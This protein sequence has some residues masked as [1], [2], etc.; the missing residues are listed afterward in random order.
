MLKYLEIDSTY[1]NRN[2][3][4]NQTQF[5]I[6]NSQNGSNFTLTTS[7]DPISIA[8][9]IV[10]YIPDDISLLNTTSFINN[11]AQ[12]PDSKI[13]SFPIS[14]KANKTS[15][16]YRGLSLNVIVN[17]GFDTNLGPVIVD[18]WD[19]LNTVDGNDCFRILFESSLANSTNSILII[20]FTISTNFDQGYVFIPNGTLASQTYKDFYIYNETQ[21]ESAIILS[22]DGDFAL[23]SIDPKP[24]WLTSDT[25]SLRK[26][27][28][29]TYG[30]FQSGSTTSS[31]VLSAS[32]DPA[33]NIYNGTFIRITQ[34]GSPNQ[35][36]TCGIKTYYGA[37]SFIASLNSALPVA[38]SDG[39]SYEILEYTRDNFFPLIYTGTQIQQEVCY[40]VQCV[41]LILPNISV[42]TG[43]V[44]Q[45]YPYL[46]VDFQNIST[47]NSGNVNV[48]YSNNPN[49]TR[50]LFKVPITD[51]S[52]PS[53]NSFAKLDKCY[54]AQVIKI[55]PYNSFKFGIYLPDG[56]PLVFSIPD[57]KSPEPPNPALQV[58]ALFSMR[59]LAAESKN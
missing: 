40:E 22:Y 20:T 52:P 5:N 41:N 58:S 54:M 14:Q 34:T 10:T 24:F 16:Y 11:T 53:L 26:K 44:L 17:D 57:T 59:R 47:S 55:T 46:L 51:I 1:R 48:I 13:I 2:E 19:Y 4:P 7:V 33:K 31:V 12:N 39:D 18:S 45:S 6:I 3:F 23:A 15:D 43:G 29:I 49:T 50:K 28:P 30:N 21:N 37:P 27:L 9:P 42:E 38:P 32:S 56:R 35:G 36:I 8:S 25:I